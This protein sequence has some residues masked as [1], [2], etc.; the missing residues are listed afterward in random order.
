MQKEHDPPMLGDKIREA[1]KKQHF[2]LSQ[3]AEAAK[4]TASY[5]SQVERNLTEPSIS[6]LRKIAAVLQMPLYRFLDDDEPQTQVIRADK[7]KRLILPDSNI[8]YEYLSPTSSGDGDL[9][10]LEVILFRLNP[11]TWSRPDYAVH[12]TADECITVLSGLLT[13]D[14]GTET[15][16][17]FEGDSTYLRSNHPHRAYNPGSD[18][19]V[20]LSCLTPPVH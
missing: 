4:L 19:S 14:C 15:Y 5:I 7:R 16:Q 8:T 13:V 10:K 20:A 18:V 17:L 1:R 9:P 6:S 2:T 3:L 12:P 11:K